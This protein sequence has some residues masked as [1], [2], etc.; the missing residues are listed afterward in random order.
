MQKTIIAT[1]I[2][3]ASFSAFA[4]NDIEYTP[5]INQNLDLRLSNNN[6]SLNYDFRLPRQQI[7]S[8][9]RITYS[10]EPQK[11]FEG[12]T[13]LA[14]KEQLS[15]NSVLNIGG[16]INHINLKAEN[17]ETLN[18]SYINIFVGLNS[19]STNKFYYKTIVSIS[20]NIITFGDANNIYNFEAEIGLSPTP[21]T[22]FFIGGRTTKIKSD[23]E[24]FFEDIEYPYAGLS[25][26]F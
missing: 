13:G 18:I 1:S 20:P 25:I 3:L 14:V 24:L 7:F 12:S 8:I 21:S 17:N 16:A 9:N 2:L 4:V 19:V 26:N 23:Y 15:L 10:E 22:K 5:P 6:V 11:S